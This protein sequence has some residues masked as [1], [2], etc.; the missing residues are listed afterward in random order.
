MTTSIALR[1][2]FD[3]TSSTYSYLLA[4][5]RRGEAVLVD[6]VFERA[7]R[8]AAL[9]RELDW[10]LVATIDT[11]VHADHVT[12]AWL[13][14]RRT[15]SR[16]VFSSASDVVNADRRVAH[17]DRV[18]FGERAL[19]VRATPGHTP[20]CI[21][22]VLDDASLAL[23]GDA[24]LV[25]GTG[26]T[27]FQGG[28]ARTLFRSVHQQIFTLPPGCVLY[29]GHDYRGIGMTTVGEE[30]RFN[31]RL[32][33][34][35]GEDDFVGYQR[36][37]DLAP[38]REIDRAVPANRSCGRPEEDMPDDSPGW[39]E[40][41]LTFAGFWEIAPAALEEA[42]GRVTLVDVRDAD[43]LHGRLGAL[44][45]ARAIPLAELAARTGEIPA[46]RPVVTVCRSGA[47]SAQAAVLLARHGKRDVASLAGGLL[48]WR[49]EGRAVVGGTD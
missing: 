6:P 8:D 44:A 34:D 23:T 1:P 36:H 49:A 24:L 26:R 18:S 43:E 45:G 28:D 12:G 14:R 17:G 35:V 46:G 5:P 38:P 41:T 16:I 22:L 15:G 19:E 37:L 29:P 10:T 11:H 48:R 39:A 27:D 9:I 2:L 13:L 40:L 42:W 7:S 21:T 31:P 47:R 30:L 25:R 33:G 20:G 3:P 4:D 32:G